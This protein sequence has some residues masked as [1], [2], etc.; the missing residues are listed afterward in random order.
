MLSDYGHHPVELASTIKALKE[1]YPDQLIHALFQP[2]Q[3]TRVVNFWD[4]FKQALSLA[5]QCYITPIYAA[6]ENFNDIKKNY[7]DHAIQ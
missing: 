1:K 4:E 5:D 6:R 3:I 2:H 7:P